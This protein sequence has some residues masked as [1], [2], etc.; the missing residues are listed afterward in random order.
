MRSQFLFILAFVF[1]GLKAQDKIYF[2]NGSSKN[3]KV[4]AVTPDH[5]ELTCEG[6]S[7]I[8]SK[9]EIILTRYA[10]GSVDVFTFPKEEQIFQPGIEAKPKA[11]LSSYRPNYASLNSLALCNSDISVFYEYLSG[12]KLFGVGVMGAYNFNLSTTFQ[13][14]FITV[15][16]SPKKN[17]DLGI[18]FNVYPVNFSKD[19][20]LYFGIMLKYTDFSF[21]KTLI[22]SSAS[23]G[24]N[25][26][27]VR[28][29]PAKGFQLA[30]LLTAGTHTWLSDHFFLRTLAGIGLFRLR[31]DY[32]EQFNQSF[33]GGGQSGNIT[34]LPK[35]YLGVNFGFNF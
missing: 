32:R 14:L 21:T 28:Y 20:A 13:N 30:T 18:T 35:I 8:I 25:G 2:L 24:G 17:Y 23:G 12:N 1:V 9:Q 29:L 5:L 11:S 6:S 19:L 22:D 7:Q 15:L 33:G 16:N 31:G 10:N 34:T 3:C 27:T 26:Y 4:E